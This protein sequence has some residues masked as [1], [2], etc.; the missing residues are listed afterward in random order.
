MYSYCSRNCKVICFKLKSM[1][2]VTLK[3]NYK[4]VQSLQQF[5]SGGPYTVS[6]DGSFIAC[7]CND[8]ITIVDTSNASIKSTIEGD[9]EA[10]T[11]LT[12]SPDDKF[13]FSASHSRQIKVW[14]LSSLKCLRS[15]KVCLRCLNFFIFDVK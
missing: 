15:W 7:A 8:T 4:C 3:K 10:V 1:S 2:S 5:Y 13:L 14:D 6:S 9:S 11:A 12:L